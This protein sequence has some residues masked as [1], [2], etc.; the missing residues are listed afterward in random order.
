MRVA[1]THFPDQAWLAD[2][3]YLLRSRQAFVYT[4]DWQPEGNAGRV[5]LRPFAMAWVWTDD[6]T[7]TEQAVTVVAESA[8]VKFAGALELPSP[9]PGRVVYAALKGRSQVTGPDGLRFD[10]DNFIFSEPAERLW[11]DHPVTFAVQGSRGRA[12]KFQA[13]LIPQSGPPGNDRPHI[14]G[15]RNVRL[16]RQVQME[17]AMKQNGEPLPLHV[18]CARSFDYNVLQQTAV[19]QEGVVAFRRTGPEEFD[20][21]EC[22]RL[23]VQFESPRPAAGEPPRDVSRPARDGEPVYQRIEPRLHFHRL[24]AESA[25]PTNPE[26]KARPV[27]LVSQRNQLRADMQTLMYDGQQRL[28][29]LVDARGVEVLQTSHKLVS[30]EITLQLGEGDSLAG[31]VCKGPGS[32]KSKDPATGAVSF[33]ADWG[34][35]LRQWRDAETGLDVLELEESAFFRQPREGAGL[36]AE[37][38]RVWLTPFAGTGALAAVPATVAPAR[39]ASAPRPEVQP[40]RL[41][42]WRGVALVNPQIEAQCQT[43]DVQITEDANTAPN[44]Q[45]API[46]L[47]AARDGQPS[48]DNPGRAAPGEPLHVKAQ[49][50]NVKLAT[51]AGGQPELREVDTQGA[52][53]LRQFKGDSE[54][55]LTINGRRVVLTNQGGV[56]QIAHI[57]GQPAWIRDSGLSI[58]GPIIHFDREENRVWVEGD[59]VL[60]IPVKNDLDGRPLLAA[61]QLNVDW[62]SQMRFDGRAATFM[63]QARALLGDREMKCETMRVTLSERISFTDAAP[64]TRAVQLGVIHCQDQVVFKNNTYEGNKLVEVQIAKVAE[65]QVDRAT[66]EMSAQGPGEMQMWRRG[67][68]GRAGLMPQQAA[69]ANA[70]TQVDTADWEYTRVDFH[71]HMDGNLLRRY[72]TFHDRV[73]VVYGPVQHAVVDTL[74]SDNLPPKGGWMQCDE[75]QV[76]QRKLPQED[77]GHIELVGRG[78]AHLEGREFYARADQITYDEA[79]GAYVLQANGKN[80]ARL[81]YRHKEGG[82]E[83]Q[84]ME[85]IP[86]THTLRATGVGGGEGGR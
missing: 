62:K 25:P 86:A 2:A 52:V 81:W 13:D 48:K 56:R 32:L 68:G 39:S 21:L 78:D 47:T 64:D 11:S 7:Q 74:N 40:R 63:G 33:A 5:R 76:M 9:E 37:L 80:K 44:P 31:A 42:A 27:R 45:S 75:L 10:G 24:V 29:T 3:K 43:L 55:P 82:A 65:F 16:S 41:M 57:Y 84:R 18:R 36:G 58:R 19:F 26:T 83:L 60:Q 69:K 61:Q 46:Q 49:T 34:K 70:P 51:V 71:G 20:S 38:I 23:T 1:Q 73:R 30:P 59:G 28:L 53:E 6:K 15:I 14:F 22:D 4:N 77:R 8:I 72:A 50:I 12:E 85:Y 54:E 35:H 67:Q 66:G 79:R 17:L